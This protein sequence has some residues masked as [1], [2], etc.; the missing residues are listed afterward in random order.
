M[1]TAGYKFVDETD[2]GTKAEAEKANVAWADGSFNKVKKIAEN[3]YRLTKVAG[4][5]TLTSTCVLDN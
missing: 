4:D 5:V 3:V 1:P 2:Y